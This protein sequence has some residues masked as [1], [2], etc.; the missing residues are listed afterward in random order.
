M[1]KKVLKAAETIFSE[2]DALADIRF[3]QITSGDDLTFNHVL[4]PC[5]VALA[6]THPAKVII[7]AGC[8]VG[9]LCDHL[10]YLKADLIG[11]DPSAQSIQLAKQHYGHL[12]IFVAETLESFSEDNESI[13]DLIVSNMV[14]MDVPNLTSFMSAISKL[15]VPGGRFIFSMGHPC[16]WPRYA[17]FADA[18]WFDY[19]EELMVEAPFRISNTKQPEIP[20]TH[21]HRPLGRYTAALREAGLGIEQLIEPLPTHEIE[22]L[23]P[24]PWEYPR[25]LVL[26]C[27]KL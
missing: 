19:R 23:Y 4:A 17:N 5:L 10:Q 12:G 18:E 3:Q 21:I 22:A 13:A 1:S 11:V 15:L 24:K 27:K 20:Y 7:D 6:K 25:F 16:F 8:G 9:V 2:W 26:E 14:V